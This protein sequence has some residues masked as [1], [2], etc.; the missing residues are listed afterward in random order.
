[1][2]MSLRLIVCLIVGVSLLSAGFA[3][4]QQRA[5]KRGLRNDLA[6][7]AEILA[8]SLG[9]NVEPLLASNIRGELQNVVTRFGTRERDTGIAVFDK[10]GNRLA[11]SPGLEGF[12][13]GGRETVLRVIARDASYGAFTTLNQAPA[14]LYVLPL[15]GESGVDG[16]LEILPD[17]SFID[18]QA[19]RMRREIYLG[20]LAQTL[21]ITLTTLLIIRWSVLRPIAR[22]AEWV[23]GLRSGKRVPHPN[24][25]EGDLFK[26]LAQEVTHLA[27]VLEAARA[28]AEEEARLREKADSLWTPERLRI[29][30]RSKLG[31][32]PLFV[33]SNREPYQHIYRGKTREVV[34]PASG[35]VTALE[36]ILRTC[37]GTWL[38]HG[39]GDADR[40]CVDERDRL[41]VPPDDPQYTLKRIWLNKEEEEGYYFGFSNEGL[42]PLCH[43]A[44]TRP[45]FRAK[46]WE[47]YQGV[48][49]KFAQALLEEMQGAVEPCVLLQD[50]H[51]ALLPRLVKQRRLDARVAIF[52]HIPWPN[53]EAFGICPW[54]RELLDGL[55]GADLLG[56]H[57]QSHCNNFLQTVD[58]TLESRVNWE[59]FS[60]ERGSHLTLVRPFPISVPPA[61]AD[62]P[63]SRAAGSTYLDRGAL[64]R[65]HSVESTFMGIGV[66]RV[67]YTKG[68]IERLRGLERFLEKY[69][70]YCGRFCLVQ[71]GEPSR[72]HIQRYH[73]L[74][75]EVEAEAARINWRFQT[76]QWRPIV[77]LQ[78]HHTHQE[79]RRYYKAADLC[80]V[81]SLH[82]GMNL[83]CKEFIAARDD[84]QGALILSRFAGA[85]QELR[86]ALI[87]NP[88]D[89]EQLAD[90]IHFALEMDPAERSA[91]MHRL[92][93]VVKE[94][95][96]YRWAGNLI[97][98]LSEI[99]LDASAEVKPRQPPAQAPTAPLE[100]QARAEAEILARPEGDGW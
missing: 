7:R 22:T 49:G 41:Q 77:Y 75:S 72:T 39:S 21:F 86:D 19:A 13:P 99:R 82:D 91:R 16:A 17:A 83:V 10:S 20:V 64:L 80:L 79:I 70:A 45:T 36:P 74:L 1:M 46:D 37:Q 98:G 63:D 65:E 32:R 60:V 40:D 94:F 84:D 56:F 28:A 31:D 57:T 62:P 89:T 35:V 27:Q 69:P 44:H 24:L 95:N 67:D 52:W 90:A 81:T 100:A 30:V 29:H 76:N 66:E 97:S 18:R 48:N 53:A 2:R 47:H 78:R 34:V 85:S 68:I 73:D 54:R 42:W 9:A 6:K 51:F 96:I 87:V 92:R 71:I 61:E 26:P 14:Y 8:E 93:Q 88:Y 55:L 58:R 43:I 23:Q 50:Y 11:V 38:A 3:I 5:E 4:F 33:V 12:L 25:A 59:R 15:H